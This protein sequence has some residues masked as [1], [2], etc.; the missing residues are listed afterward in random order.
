MGKMYGS[1]HLIPNDEFQVHGK[2]RTLIHNWCYDRWGPTISSHLDGTWDH[3]ID[4]FVFK[5]EDDKIEF[6]LRWL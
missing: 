4:G 5:H 1:Y 6:I 3:F 2:H